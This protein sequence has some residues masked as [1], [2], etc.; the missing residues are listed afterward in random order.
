MLNRQEFVLAGNVLAQGTLV[1]ELL[2]A[3]F[4]RTIENLTRL[5]TLVHHHMLLKVTS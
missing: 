5:T 1:S 3:S 4:L 2:A